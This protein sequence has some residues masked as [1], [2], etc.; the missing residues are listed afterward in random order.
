MTPVL[1]LRVAAFFRLL[2]TLQHLKQLGV[3]TAFD[4]TKANFSKLSPE[5]LYISDVLQSVSIFSE[6]L[7]CCVVVVSC[8]CDRRLASCTAVRQG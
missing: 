8:A 3:K 2:L 1:L 6:Q 4:R 7:W 5:P